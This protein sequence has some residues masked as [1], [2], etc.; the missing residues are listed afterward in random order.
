[1]VVL[2]VLDV[3]PAHDLDL[4]KVGVLLVLRKADA[5]G[6]QRTRQS[7]LLHH[8]SESVKAGRGSR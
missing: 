7:D 4:S 1:M 8:A 3:I 6:T 5:K 2:T